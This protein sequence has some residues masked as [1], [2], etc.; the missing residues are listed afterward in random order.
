MPAKLMRCVKDVKKQAR[1]DHPDW[2]DDRVNSYAYAVC[3]KST[4]QHPGDEE[5]EMIM[6]ALEEADCHAAAG[7]NK[8]HYAL[9]KGDKKSDWALPYKNA[10]GSINKACVRNALARWNQVQGYSDAQKKAALAKLRRAARSV[11]VEVGDG[12]MEDD[13]MK[14]TSSISIH[15]SFDSALSTLK[16]PAVKAMYGLQ[17][18]RFDFLEESSSPESETHFYIVGDA[19][20]PVTTANLHTYLPEELEAAAESLA[21]VPIMVDH[22]K[23]SENVAGKV[24]VSAWEERAGL[25]STISYVGRIRKTHPVAEAVKVGDITTVSIGADAEIIECSICG[26]DMRYCS[27]HIGKKYETSEGSKLATAIGRGLAFRELSI[28]PFPADRRATAHA[29]HD[30]MFSAMEMLV[31][32]S[33]YKTQLQKAGIRKMSEDNQEELALAEEIRKLKA[34]KEQ[35]HKEKE[36]ADKEIGLFHEREKAAL[37]DRVFEMEVAAN[38]SKSEDEKVRKTELKAKSTEVLQAK[39]D[40]L[41]RFSG[42]LEKLDTPKTSGKAVVATEPEKKDTLAPLTYRREEVKAGIREAL[43]GMRTSDYAQKT[44]RRWALDP[45]NPRYQEYQT[46]V[47]NNIKKVLGRNE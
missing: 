42:I 24:L 7:D 5:K 40:D 29:T 8:S 37:V 31:E 2:D 23:M 28:T 21:G 18:A 17:E 41:K 22:A 20:H 14:W 32:S 38:I 36:E 39:I 13:T 33:E 1:E 30:S 46:L 9:T 4:G 12:E 6:L 19:I 10:D 11:G 26:E 27:H 3:V 43:G 45:Q 16:R 25:D 34:E 44:V 47:K 15:E 35:L